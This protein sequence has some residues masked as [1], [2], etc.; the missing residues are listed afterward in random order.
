MWGRSLRVGVR[1][2]WLG[3]GGMNKCCGGTGP[4]PPVSASNGA[5]AD[6]KDRLERLEHPHGARVWLRPPNP[7]NARKN[8]LVADVAAGFRRHGRESRKAADL[9]LADV[10]LS[11]E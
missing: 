7:L 9:L 11:V 2:L 1:R 10:E 5:P 6:R 8:G 4:R 3:V